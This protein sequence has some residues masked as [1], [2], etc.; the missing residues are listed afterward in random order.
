MKRVVSLEFNRLID[1]YADAAELDI[2]EEN[3][4]REK[5]EGERSH[6]RNRKT[7]PGFSRLR[8]NLGKADGFYPNTLIDMINRNI[9]GRIAI[10]K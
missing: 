4:P 8:I 3:T 9:P 5:K 10:G 1:Y 2:P 6:N 7:A